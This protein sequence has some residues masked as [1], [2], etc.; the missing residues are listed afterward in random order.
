MSGPASTMVFISIA[1]PSRKIAGAFEHSAIW[2]CEP[3]KVCCVFDFPRER[4]PGEFG[5]V[6]LPPGKRVADFDIEAVGD[7]K[8]YGLHRN[9]LVIPEFC[10][11]I[12]DIAMPLQAAGTCQQRGSGRK[13]KS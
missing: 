4:S 12:F 2:R 7:L 8:R 6:F 3:R 5:E 9:I 1:F 13:I 11:S 10:V